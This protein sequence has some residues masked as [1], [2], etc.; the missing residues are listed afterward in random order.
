MLEIGQDRYN[1][2]IGM[3]G[4]T[5]PVPFQ[6]S[7]AQTVSFHPIGFPGRYSRIESHV[8]IVDDVWALVATRASVAA[9]S[10]STAAAI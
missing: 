1:I 10:P 3:S 8:V 4:A 2:L 5:P 6:L 9:I 7:P